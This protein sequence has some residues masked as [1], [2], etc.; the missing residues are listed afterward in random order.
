MRKLPLLFACAIA[1]A[2]GVAGIA[3]AVNSKQSM[4]ISLAKN[5]AGTPK[6]PKDIGKLT[7]DLAVAVDQTDAPFATKTTTLF[8]DKNLVFNSAKFKSCTEAQ[9]RAGAAACN[10]AKVGSGIAQ[11]NALGQQENL[12]V[13]A[14]NGPGGKSLL[15]RVQGQTP[16]VIDSVII[17]KLVNGSGAYGKKLVV[18]IP[19]NLQQPLTGVYATLTRFKTTVGGVQKKVPYIGL[20]GCPASKKLQFKGDFVFTDGTKQ[21]PSTTAAC[22]K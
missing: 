14:Y 22:K 15:L 17:G 9:V 18:T 4:S 6:A 20:K 12:T 2:L 21:S 11:A 5:K 3:Q 19:D 13:K 16:L 10:A 7:V 1:L 8:F